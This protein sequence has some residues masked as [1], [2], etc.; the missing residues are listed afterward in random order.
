MDAGSDAEVVECADC[1]EPVAPE[2]DVVY[3]FGNDS[4]ICMACGLRRGGRYN[5]ADDRWVTE[6][7]VDALLEQLESRGV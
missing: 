5:A 6:P 1:R 4:V 7:Q 2:S 3:A